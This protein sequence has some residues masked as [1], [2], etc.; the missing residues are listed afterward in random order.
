MV[1]RDAQQPSA[2]TAG[3]SIR[4]QAPISSDK[5]LSPQKSQGGRTI[6]AAA[7]L[8]EGGY[9]YVVSDDSSIVKINAIGHDA[10]GT[11]V[12]LTR[13]EYHKRNF[14][15]TIG[16]SLAG[17]FLTFVLAT[18]FVTA[19]KIEDDPSDKPVLIL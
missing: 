6:S 1:A 13:H 7:K 14:Q 8:L 10:E 3:P 12:I 9:L 4:P 18:T 19:R 17:C 15:N 11:L 5:D 2:Q 16:V